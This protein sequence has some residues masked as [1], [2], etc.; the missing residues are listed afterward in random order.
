VVGS[1]CEFPEGSDTERAAAIDAL[2]SQP[3]QIAFRLVSMRHS[4][5]NAGPTKYQQITLRPKVE[6]ACLY[7]ATARSNNNNNHHHHNNNDDDDDDDCDL[8]H[9][10][11]GRGSN[12]LPPVL[13]NVPLFRYLKIARSVEWK[14][15]IA[16]STNWKQPLA[17]S[18]GSSSDGLH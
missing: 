17:E 3:F 1:R 18:A 16:G 4:G 12:R 5:T 10:F 9:M 14:Q 11:G 13:K 7:C 2:I 6:S 8:N 15:T